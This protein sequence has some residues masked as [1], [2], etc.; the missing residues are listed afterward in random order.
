MKNTKEENSSRKDNRFRLNPKETEILENLRNTGTL[1]DEH[2]I[3]S[4]I[5]KTNLIS[6]HNDLKK[7]YQQSLKEITEYKN[8]I[9][10]LT[11]LKE[12]PVQPYKITATKGKQESESTMVLVA[13]DWHLE[14]T[15]D[16]STV[17]NLNE[18]NL[19]IAKERADT[20]F[21]KSLLMY[22]L[23]GKNFNIQKIILALLGDFINGYIHP[24]FVEENALS[25]TQ[26]ILFCKELLI[27]GIDFLLENTDI[28]ELTIPCCIGN[29]GR[30]TD[31]SRI[32]SAYKNSFEWMMYQDLAM[33]YQNN[34]RIKFVISNSYHNYI[35]LYNNYTIRFHHGD[36]L[37]YSGGISGISLPAMKA[38]SQW[39]KAIPVNLDVFAHFHQLIEGEKFIANGSLVGFNSFAIAIK[40]AYEKPQQSM[41]VINEQHGKI[42]SAP[43]LLN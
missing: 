9:N 8:Q 7:R 29:H 25:P 10:L 36:Q 38:I 19:E 28:E 23:L 14:E 6:K 31:K 37:K 20:F 43:I 33:Y 11:E 22:Q 32:A 21:K 26:S 18:F 12:N 24:E 40:A 41:F 13:S 2:N 42:L 5:N 3:A 16:P 15:V 1:P 4:D 30:T 34:K 39:N 17:N 35:N 27:S